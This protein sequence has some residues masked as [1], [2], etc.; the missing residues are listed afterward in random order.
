ML[1][2]TKQNFSEEIEKSDKTG[3]VIDAFATWYGPCQYMMP[4]YRRLEKKFGDN[5][6]ATSTLMNN[7][8]L[9]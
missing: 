3:V 9:Q 4:R 6:S 1:N 8:S 7:V 2:I 5:S